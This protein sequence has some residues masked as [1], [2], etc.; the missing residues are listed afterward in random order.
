[1]EIDFRRQNINL[2][3]LLKTVPALKGFIS[4]SSNVQK[5]VRR[6]IYVAGVDTLARFVALKHHNTRVGGSIT[7]L[8]SFNTVTL[9]PITVF[10]TGNAGPIDLTSEQNTEDRVAV[11]DRQEMLTHE[12]V[13]GWRTGVITTLDNVRSHWNNALTWG[14]KRQ[15]LWV[16]LS[17]E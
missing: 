3:I 10:L 14:F 17:V 1:M 4:V 5:H 2:Y 12:C 8:G 7:G 11:K 15:S 9:A 6:H 13:E 16:N